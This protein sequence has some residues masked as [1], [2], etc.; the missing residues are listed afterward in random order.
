MRLGRS[1]RYPAGWDG[2][3]IER[4]RVEIVRR[5]TGGSAVLHV[6]EVTFALAASVP[7]PW[8][9]TPRGFARA[10]AL[11]LSRALAACGLG[12]SRIQGAGIPDPGSAAGGLC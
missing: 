2:R 3:S 11:A 6:E 8:R 4:S 5:T 10:A 12:E 9:L 7:G 1:G